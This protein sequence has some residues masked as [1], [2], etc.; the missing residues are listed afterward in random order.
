[1]YEFFLTDSLE[2]VFPMRRP[3]QLFDTT[4][5]ALKGEIPAVQL[6]YKKE[7][8]PNMKLEHRKFTV[9]IKGAPVKE[10]I[11]KV[12]L[13]QSDFPAYERCD[14]NYIDTSPGLFPDSLEEMETDMILPLANQFRALWI[15]FPN[16]TDAEPGEYRISV[17]LVAEPTTYFF[18]GTST[19]YNEKL[20]VKYSCEFTLNILK[21]QLPKQT[22]LHT[23]WFHAD[24]L[25]QYYNTKVFSDE[26]WSAI[27]Q[28]IKLA[29]QELG[30]NTILTPVFTPPLDTAV[31]TERLTVQLVE[32]FLD[33]GLYSFNFDNLSRWCKICSENNISHIEV[34][35]F[36]T[37]WGAQATPKIVA[38]VD[39]EDKKIFGWDIPSTSP[40]YRRFLESFV[41]ALQN[42]LLKFGY[43]KDHVIYHISDEPSKEHLE[44]YKAAK[45]QVI[46]LLAGCQIIDALSDYEYY[47]D[48]LV[49]TPVPADDHIEPFI[50]NNTP[51]LW[52]YYC[53][54]QCIDVP[55][56]FYS[57]PS[58]RNRIMGVLMYLYDIKG[59]LHWGYNFYNSQFSFKAINPYVDT[60][61]NYAFPSGDPYLVYPGDNGKPVSSIRAQVQR[62][63]ID[64]MRLLQ[65]VE[66]KIGKE[67]V[68]K[69]I[70][71]GIDYKITFKNYPKDSEYFFL[72]RKN[73]EK[74]LIE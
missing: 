72:L 66:T 55:N 48:G 39:G 16:L 65:F 69:I 23:E 36:F 24:S 33:N 9:K 62:Q 61:A 20:P 43:D 5:T 10:R 54:A 7:C 2:K 60:H 51:N 57:M 42:A 52:V 30:I 21:E 27:E 13:I 12:G 34:A 14:T 56:R 31:G 40:E 35:H 17:E 19:S 50:E 8:A 45:E 18:N 68:E 6:V 59:F 74:A 67:E 3:R 25:A 1:M 32:V 64:D 49:Q 4:I 70:Y 63:A 73:L 11:R 71:G 37:Q 15:D 38:K 28:Q 46:D 22:L 58:E 26:H 53:C 47:K 41:P 29:G 44:S